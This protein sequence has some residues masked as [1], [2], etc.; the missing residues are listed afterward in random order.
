LRRWSSQVTVVRRSVR[1]AASIVGLAMLGGCALPLIP[2][3]APLAVVVWGAIGAE[4]LSGIGKE[5]A[6]GEPEPQALMLG[7][8]RQV[9]TP[10]AVADGRIDPEGARVEDLAAWLSSLGLT[11][12]QVGE[13]NVVVVQVAVGEMPGDMAPR[14]LFVPM[15]RGGLVVSP[16]DIV[17]ARVR[18][19]RPG[20]LVR[21]RPA[22]TPEADCRFV[23]LA[24][25]LAVPDRLQSRALGDV[26]LSAT[27][28]CMGIE[29]QGWVRP[30]AFWVK[31]S[32]A[33]PTAKATVLV[34]F[35]RHS[36]FWDPRIVLAV[37]AAGQ[38]FELK[39][40]QCRVLLLPAGRHA[41]R[42]ANSET[43]L[44]LRRSLDVDVAADDRVVVEFAFDAAQFAMEEPLFGLRHLFDDDE[45]PSRYVHF[46]AR[47]AAPGEACTGSLAP[48]IV[49][50]P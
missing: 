33:L 19:E 17:E 39:N 48:L 47:P 44:P 2:A 50:G 22:G 34:F 49:P 46:S 41:V 7:Q 3:T 16:G 13:G 6:P 24:G 4:V 37:V 28:H 11:P 35:R 5:P 26:R 42:V 10:A 12:R 30:A 9:L 8:V 18:R 38:R 36:E 14:R 20:E 40:G 15:L 1:T 25:G 27:L 32:G 45:P 43:G 29:D 21:V 23:D 31:S